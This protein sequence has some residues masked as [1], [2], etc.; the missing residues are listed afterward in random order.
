MNRILR[1][2]TATAALT[3]LSACGGAEE[4]TDREVVAEP[5]AEAA[6]GME[7]M[8]GMGGME[9]MQQ[10]A[11]SAPLQRHME[12]MEGASGDE[13]KRMIPEHRQLVA[14]MIAQMNREMRGMNM[15]GDTEWNETVNA[16]R[17]D[18]VRLPEMPAEELEGFMPEH[19]TRID[20]LTE[21]HRSMMGDMQM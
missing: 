17:N 1:G 13:L 5:A 7:G 2:V 18:L 6:E 21:M 10:D 3:L 15:S 8:Q 4:T 9:G 14:N 20:R 16:L 19:R 11:A 12:M